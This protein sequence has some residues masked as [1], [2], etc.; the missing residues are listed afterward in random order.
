MDG[1]G[2]FITHCLPKGPDPMP[3]YRVNLGFAKLPDADLSQFASTVLTAMTDNPA[4]PHLAVPLTDL[5]SARTAFAEALAATAQGG[6]QA[7]AAKN[8]ARLVLTGL[9]RQMAYYV[10]VAMED[11]LTVLLSSGFEAA[12]NNRTPSPLPAPAILRIRNEQTT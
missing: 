5:A 3:A 9:L 10:Q 7:T 2:D 12:S 8:A 4:F 1:T 6:M 11:D